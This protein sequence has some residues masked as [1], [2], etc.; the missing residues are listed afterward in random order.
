MTAQTVLW[1]FPALLGLI[2]LGFPVAL[3]MMIAALGFGLM[4]F[5]GTLVHQFAQRIDDLSTNYVL[6][7]IPL[8]IF[9][10]SILERAGIAERLFDALYMWTRR[11]PGGLAIAALLMCTIF[12]AASGV[13][14]ATETLVGMLAIPAMVK[15]RYD[16]KLIAGTICG[17]GSLGTI[18]PPSVPVVVL[19]PIATLPIG[20][21]LAGILIPGLTMSALFILYILIA[22]GLKP[23]LAPPEQDPD[24]RSLGEKIRFT[25]VALVP[26][27]FLIFT[28]LGTLFTGMATPT[29]AAAC[30]SLGVLLLAIV[31]RRMT[32]R[33]L[34]QASLQTVG[35]TAMIL[36]IILAGGMFSGVF[37]ASGGMTATKG[38]LDALGLSPWSVVAAILF[39]VFILGFIVDSISI[40]LIVTP[41]AIPLVKSFGLDPLW[42]SVV[43]LVMLQTAY[44]TPP[45]APSI[46][47]LKA[48]A[49]PTMRLQDMY[50]G[51]IPFIICQIVVLL[52]L[53]F[54]PGMATWMPKVM[55]G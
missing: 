10:G 6:G 53:L 35:L 14:G 42:F 32:W 49:P 25:L 19:A 36:A 8:F 43:M 16:N 39:V 27:G 12:A 40:I 55:Y 7:A 54:F 33:L 13:V 28:V 23:S 24:P 52:L 30:G 4:R 41:I 26:P 1:M 46:F 3:S 15:R 50:W 29:E 37:F 44:L 47:Y 45:M 20:D 11:L 34:F 38:I 51:V 21:L 2:F 5:G 22:C 18:I 9:M 48:I 17:G 31:Y